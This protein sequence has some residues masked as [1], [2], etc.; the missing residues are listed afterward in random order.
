M[1]RRCHKDRAASTSP[2]TA[3]PRDPNSTWLVAG[4]SVR[5][6]PAEARPELQAKAEFK[7]AIT[8]LPRLA[9]SQP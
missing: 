1:V 4:L 2:Q 7:A 3:E 5:H 9:A 6:T 8:S